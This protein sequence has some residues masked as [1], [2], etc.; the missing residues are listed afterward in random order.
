MGNTHSHS[1][2]GAACLCRS[3]RAGR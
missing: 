1:E 3:G 2:P